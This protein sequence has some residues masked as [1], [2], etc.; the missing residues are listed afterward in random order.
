MNVKRAAVACVAAVT[1]LSEFSF[2]LVGNSD[3][4]NGRMI[5]D[6]IH[7]DLRKRDLID[8]LISC[9]SSNQIS[10]VQDEAAFALANLAKDFANKAD[11]RKSGGI[12]ALI[13]VLDS[14]DPDVKKN[15]GLA[16]AT[17]L[18]DCVFYFAFN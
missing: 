1:E 6:E 12:R 17:L 10:E 5:L 9:L 18:D 2:P 3:I 14:P 7:P 13:R 15:A 16:L 4:A 11:I 8:V